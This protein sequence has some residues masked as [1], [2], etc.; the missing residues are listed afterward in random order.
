MR[1]GREGKGRGVGKGGAIRTVGMILL[2]ARGEE[3]E[4]EEDEYYYCTCLFFSFLII[5]CV[6][7]VEKVEAQR[8][9][10]DWAIPC[11]CS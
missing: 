8:N 10:R 1:K 6:L 5:L 4:E 3:E 9:P 2:C 11:R 7:L